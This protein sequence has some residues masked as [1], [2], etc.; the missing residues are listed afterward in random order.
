M[1]P[2]SLSISLTGARRLNIVQQHLAGRLPSKVTAEAMLGV[3]RD[4]GYVQWD[5]VTVVAPSHLLSFWARLG[6]FPT[7]LLERLLWRDKTLFEH[8]TPM[9]SLV[10]TEDYPLYLSLMERYPE[11]LTRSWGNHRDAAKRF[12]SAQTDLRKKVLRELKKGPR[13]VGQFRDHR[14]TKRNDGEWGS[15]SDVSLMLFHLLMRG[16]VMVVGHDGPQ[17]LWGLSERFLPDWVERRALSAEEAE[18][19]AA[20]RAI[21]ALGTASPREITLYFPRGRYMDL[22]GTLARLEAESLIHRVKVDG[23]E[24]RDERYIHHRDL[25]LLES[26]EGSRFEPRV[27]LLPP[28]DNLL[29]SQARGQRLFGFDYIREQFLP[30]EKR[31]FGTYVLP[32]VWGERLIGRIDPRLDKESRTLIVNAVHAEPGAPSER[33]V[34]EKIDDAV[35]SLARFIGARKVRYPSRVPAEWRSALR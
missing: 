1:S 26:L 15:A 30:R 3:V 5:P 35:A 9:A 33:D 29:Y 18:R 20:Q 8:W 11:S 4:L 14:T 23:W 32:I 2:D 6:E 27:S 31:R 22:K 24:G 19:A 28:F 21:R 13:T 25:L 17:N 16:E 10:L 34:A 12:L 7:E